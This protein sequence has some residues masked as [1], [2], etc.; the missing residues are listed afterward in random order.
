MH[1]LKSARV[2]RS[3]P[4]FSDFGIRMYTYD[5]WYTVDNYA[6]THNYVHVSVQINGLGMGGGIGE[7]MT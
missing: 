2:I 3:V 5:L 7:D 4:I 1:F 6:C